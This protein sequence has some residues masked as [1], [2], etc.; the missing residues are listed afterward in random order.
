MHPYL[1]FNKD[2]SSITHVGLKLQ[3]SSGLIM[4]SYTNTIISRGISGELL[5]FFIDKVK[6]PTEIRYSNKLSIVLNKL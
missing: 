6:I 2:R 4:D 3:K 5:Q 1:F